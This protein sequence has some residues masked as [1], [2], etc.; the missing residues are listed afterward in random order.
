LTIHG[1]RS[2][3]YAKAATSELGKTSI[4][5]EFIDAQS[6]KKKT[7]T[8]PLTEISGYEEGKGYALAQFNRRMKPLLLK[9]ADK[10]TDGLKSEIDRLENFKQFKMYWMLA[11]TYGVLEQR[12]ETKEDLFKKLNIKRG[13]TYETWKYFKRDMLNKIQNGVNKTRVAFSFEADGT[14]ENWTKVT[15]TYLNKPA[16]GLPS[17]VNSL[18]QD[19]PDIFQSLSTVTIPVAPPVEMPPWGKELLAK[20]LFERSVLDLVARVARGEIALEYIAFVVGYVESHYRNRKKEEKANLMFKGIMDGKYNQQYADSTQKQSRPP[21]PKTSSGEKPP[22]A[23]T[24]KDIFY[25][26]E[27]AE[28]ELG[29][30]NALKREQGLPEKSITDYW[31]DILKNPKYRELTYMGKPVIVI[32]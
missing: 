25:T 20:G 29:K 16:P 32:R 30:L 5:I 23:Y 26:W 7:V 17:A 24:A 14:G 19:M 21:A 27:E 10:S 1:G 31:N 6:G 9:L 8:I 12:V 18:Q 22:S 28:T 11:E 4:E 13:G 15:F 2:Y 3:E